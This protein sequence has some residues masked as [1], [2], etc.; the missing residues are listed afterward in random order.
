MKKVYVL[1]AI[2][3]FAAC[4]KT[5]L[6]PQTT[7][8]AEEESEAR[9]PEALLTAHPWMYNAF[10]MH[11][12]DADHKGDPLYVRG[13]ANN[14]DEIIGTDRFLFKPNHN[15]IQK[16]GAYEYRGTWQFTATTPY[17][18]VMTYDWGTNDDVLVQFDSK[19]LNYFHAFGYHDQDKSYTELIPATR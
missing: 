6:S 18:L 3:L 10:Y 12:I 5:G 7:T 17:T 13:A 9:S 2:T 8:R 4:S 15:F 14:E 19:H 1:A 16:E 11:Y